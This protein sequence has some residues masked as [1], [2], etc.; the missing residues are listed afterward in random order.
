MRAKGASEAN[1]STPGRRK[2]AN[3][4]NPES[5]SLMTIASYIDVEAVIVIPEVDF[6]EYR[7]EKP[8]ARVPC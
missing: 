4:S 5:C 8:T 7:S 1:T 6:G 3:S 2:L